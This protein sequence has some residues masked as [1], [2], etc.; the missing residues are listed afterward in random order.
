MSDTPSSNLLPSSAS[1]PPLTDSYLQRFS[2]IGRLYGM[3]AL[4]HLARAHFVI[5]GIGGVGTWVAEA[6]ARSGIGEITLIDMDDICITNSN[7]QLH[8]LASTIGQSKVAVIAE[9]L[10]GINPEIVVHE[11]EDFVERETVAEQIPASADLV[12]DAIDVVNV[13]AAIIAHCKYR[14]KLVLT[15][16]SAGGKRDPRQVSTRDLSKTTVDPL[17]AKTRNFLRR[18]YNFSRNPKSNFTVEAIYSTE[19]MA[20]P[21]AQGGVCASKEGMDSGVKLDCS[22]G[23][24]S[25]TMLTG[26][27]GFVAASRSIEKYLDKLRREANNCAATDLNSE[28]DAADT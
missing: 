12:V 18:F 10:R 3:S 17:L 14:K 13:K 16:G 9:R 6:L 15:V 11:V 26:T 5:V 25:S 2:G 23:F 21:D 8:T 1:F 22:G 7:R 19:Q 27:F 20:Y 4:P 24:G 28:S